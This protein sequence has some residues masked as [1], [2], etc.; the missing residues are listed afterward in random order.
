MT[1]LTRDT[2]VSRV[3]IFFHHFE[4]SQKLAD[5]AAR[6]FLPWAN[7]LPH[8]GGGEDLAPILQEIHKLSKTLWN[9]KGRLI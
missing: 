5:L 2:Q 3:G 6:L 4:F 1:L 7:D 8:G 9:M